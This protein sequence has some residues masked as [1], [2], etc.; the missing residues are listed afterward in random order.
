MFWDKVRVSTQ[1]FEQIVVHVLV[2]VFVMDK[3]LRLGVVHIS[4]NQSRRGGGGGGGGGFQ[5]IVLV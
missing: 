4:R 1:F 2:H 3:M 5:M